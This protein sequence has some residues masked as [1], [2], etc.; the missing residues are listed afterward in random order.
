MM[1]QEM[2][3]ANKAAYLEEL[4][5][6]DAGVDAGPYKADW[7]DLERHT[8]AP[9][10]FRDAKL[11]IY[12]HWGIYTVTGLHE[13]Y[14]K[15]MFEVDRVRKYHEKTYG[16]VNDYPYQKF[17]DQFTGEY[18]D[19]E[20]WASL[21]KESGAK[22]AG[23]VSVHIDGFAMWDSDITPWNAAGYGPKRDIVGELAKAIKAQDMKFLT[24]FHHAGTP[25][26]MPREQ[27]SLTVS[28]D[29]EMRMRY[30]NYSYEDYSK[31]F[32]SEL[33][34]VIDKYQ[35]DVIWFDNGMKNIQP[36]LIH[37]KF[38]AYYFNSAEKWGK[39]VVVN[40]KKNDYPPSIAVL[41]FERGGS[42]YLTRDPWL[43]D[44][45]VGT[46][47]M[48]RNMVTPFSVRPAKEILTW[49]L[50]I[51]SKN[52]CLLLN[53]SPTTDG[54]ITGDQRELLK[55]I[56]DWLKVNGEAVYSTRPWHAFGEGPNQRMMKMKET[57]KGKEWTALTNLD[58]RYTQSKDQSAIYAMIMGWNDDITLASIK[59][60]SSKGQV[61][62][63][64]Y[65]PVEYFVNDEG[66]IHI[67]YPN[68]SEDKRPCKYAYC[69]KITGFEPTLHPS[70]DK[71]WQVMDSGTNQK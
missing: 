29:P 12:F 24:S 69:F 67:S 9:E 30:A 32:L 19:P 45:F 56:G 68:I 6:I 61:E 10:W 49:F 14:L 43:C 22:F 31:I 55:E 40:T 15:Q 48:Y 64:G 26:W 1:A 4:K 8:A 52:G 16:P 35:P 70:V 18:F 37:E 66:Q 57:G 5:K 41:D 65:G 62:M 34:E 20:E 58:V 33:G 63:L 23:P 2:P 71:T 21:F 11:G 17:V 27:G 25:A 36:E 51:V 44:D 28:T 50:T 47:W 54:R 13:L 53:L 46:G 3:K 38:L 39:E 7:E 42:K 59:A 60:N